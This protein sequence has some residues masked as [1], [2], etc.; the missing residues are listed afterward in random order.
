MKKV[1]LK[2]LFVGLAVVIFSTQV[3]AYLTI[4]AANSEKEITAVVYFDETEIYSA[5]T[6][7][8]QLVSYVQ[9]NDGVTF[10]DVEA[11]HSEMIS[12]VS[13]SSALAFHDGD[14]NT[15]PIFS[16]FI[17]GCLLNGLGMLIVGL[18]TD[19]DGEQIMKSLWGCLISSCLWGGSY[20]WYYYGY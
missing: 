17:W 11:N 3:K 15:P 2:F 14:H 12:N 7:V 4:E 6:N 8:D 16:A 20:G 18:T 9:V 5:F 1:L 10:Y 13:S 19:F